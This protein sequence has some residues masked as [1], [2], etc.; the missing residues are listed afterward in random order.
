MRRKKAVAIVFCRIYLLSVASIMPAATLAEEQTEGEGPET[1]EVPELLITSGVENPLAPNSSGEGS[2]TFGETYIDSLGQS[3][4]S[5]DGVLQIVPGV[6][7]SEDRRDVDS[8][9]DLKPSSISISGGR[10]YENN[11]VL[12]GLSNSSRLDPASDVG[13]GAISDVGGH[14]QA[15]FVDTDLLDEVTV[16]DSNVPAAYGG[17]TG[18]VVDASTRRP[19]D[20]AEGKISV[21]GTRS[22]WTE[23]RTLTGNWDPNSGDLPPVPPEEPEFQRYRASLSY[24]TPVTD[25]LGILGSLT[26]SYSETPSVSLGETRNRIQRN[27]NLLGKVS[28]DVAPSAILDLSATWAPYRSESFLTD[29]KDSDYEVEGGGYSLKGEWRYS[30]PRVDHSFHLGW[31]RNVNQRTAPNGFFNWR[32]TESRQWGREAD[33]GSSREGGYGDL[34]K[35][36]DSFS[37]GHTVTIAPKDEAGPSFG[38]ETGFEFGHQRYRFERDQTLYVND[39]AVINTEVEC[40]ALTSDCVQGEQYFASRRVYP[41]DDV[42]V[43][44]NTAGL[45][46]ET[47]LHYGRLTTSFGIRYDYDDFLRNHDIA[48]R[49]R[50]T[51]AVFGDNRT[52]LIAGA[53]RYYGAPLLTYRLR[54]AREPFYRQYRS[55][56]RN[57]VTDWQRRSGAGEFRYRFGNVDTPFSDEGTL[58]LEQTLFGGRMTL[59][60]VA[61]NNEDE[62]A[63]TITDTQPDGFRYYLMNNNG[64]SRYRGVSFAWYATYGETILNIQS[65][66]SETETSNADYDDPVN[67]TKP[68][69]FV[70]YNGERVPFGKLDILRDNFNR[71]IVANISVAHPLTESLSGTVNTRFRSAYDQIV[72]TGNEVEGRLIETG[73]GEV[74]RENLAEYVD[75]EK[76]RTLF[77]D[78]SLTYARPFADGSKLEAGV[79]IRNLLDDRTYS[80]PSSQSGIEPGRQIWLNSSIYF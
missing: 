56:D 22:E 4:G 5:L 76:N 36:Q 46:G 27:R 23:F 25:T 72:R 73:D 43:S 42:E 13:G 54:E 39:N 63:R 14:E 6:Q 70:S 17:F 9:T 62:F 61:R 65:T 7:F 24:S 50:A 58:G 16:Y 49:T 80:V 3:D 74:V 45:F 66:W 47:T 59:K 8:L 34:D 18:G 64:S 35:Q 2:Y 41:A 67:A 19:G 37:T 28:F 51:F 53:N 55:T 1:F 40:R 29:V 32:N 57:I 20:Q 52:V 33:V 71:P 69:E 78:I 31:T 68:S 26:E 77:F 12:D 30:G 15:L 21:N 79:E 11:F 48:P 44:L 10:F 60:L 75:E 38:Y